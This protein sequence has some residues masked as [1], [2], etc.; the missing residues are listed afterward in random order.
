MELPF[1]SLLISGFHTAGIKSIP[2][3]VSL[4]VSS[5]LWCSCP[6]RLISFSSF[7]SNGKTT[8]SSKRFSRVAV[9]SSNEADDMSSGLASIALAP[10]AGLLGVISISASSWFALFALSSASPCIPDS[11][12]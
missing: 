8:S 6:P 5:T 7:M 3:I 12:L 11:S 9:C 10:S 1:S 2:S 4:T